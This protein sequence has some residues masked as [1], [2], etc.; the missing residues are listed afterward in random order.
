MTMP[1][2]ALAGLSIGGGALNLPFTKGL[3]F[4]ALWLERCRNHA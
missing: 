1:L 4:L 3:L 2:V